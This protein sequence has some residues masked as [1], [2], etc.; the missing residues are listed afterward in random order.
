M[1]RN[2]VSFNAATHGH[3]RRVY[4]GEY[5]CEGCAWRHAIARD[6]SVAA[7]KTGREAFDKHLIDVWKRARDA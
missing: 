6:T 2:P 3:T 7:D 4:A 5:R 1:I